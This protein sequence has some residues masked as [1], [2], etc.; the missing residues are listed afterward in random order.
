MPDFKEVI[1]SR[2]EKATVA[3]FQ[4]SAKTGKLRVSAWRNI[5]EIVKDLEAGTK[6]KIRNI[7]A[8]KRCKNR[9]ELSSTYCT[10][11]ESLGKIVKQ[12]TLR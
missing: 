8:K 12:K 1:T 3:S 7:Y 4:L 6:V 5:A 11:I 10:T 2:N 9:I